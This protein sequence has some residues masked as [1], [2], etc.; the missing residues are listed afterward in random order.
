MSGPV[1][2]GDVSRRVVN[3][4][5]KQPELTSMQKFN[6]LFWRLV[7]LCAA[8][9]VGLGVFNLLP[10]PMLD[11]GAVATETWHLATRKAVPSRVIELSRLAGAALLVLLMLFITVGDVFETGIFAGAGS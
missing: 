2:I 4:I 5:W 6:E 8:I 10:F 1:G 11:G 7:S 3:N 9:S